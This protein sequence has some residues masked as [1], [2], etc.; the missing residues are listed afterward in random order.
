MSEPGHP[1]T[2]HGR[3][4]EW[5]LYAWAV[6]APLTLPVPGPDGVRISISDFLGAVTL[7][8]I[9]LTLLQRP[10]RAVAV[11]PVA[12]F[13]SWAL[14]CTI[15]NLPE[16]PSPIGALFRVSRA[17]FIA[18]PFL[19]AALFSAEL[20]PRVRSRVLDL[21][22]FGS[23]LGILIGIAAYYLGFS[24]VPAQTYD[25]GRGLVARATGMMGDAGAFG[26]LGSSAAALAL[27]LFFIER[28]PSFHRMILCFAL[29]AIM[30]LFFYTSLARAPLVDLAV[31]MLAIIGFAAFAIYRRGRVFARLGIAL[32]CAVAALGFV[33]EAYPVEWRTAVTRLDLEAIVAFADDPTSLLERLGS[34]RSNVWEE[35]LSLAED[36]IALGLGYKGLTSQYNLPGDN[37]FITTFADLGLPGVLILGSCLAA[38]SAACLWTTVQAGRTDLT[39][40]ILGPVWLGQLVHTIFV[41]IT[42]FYSSFPLILMIAGLAIFARPEAIRTGALSGSW[43]YRPGSWRM[44]A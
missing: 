35:S 32:G 7:V 26:H 22:M 6:L 31:V 9:V 42:T 18:S 30:P 36:H 12:I 8:L 34:G 25:Y 1:A 23:L 29:I 38:F 19:L 11:V 15:Y 24:V 37:L 28:R 27:C 10:R 4:A 41:D 16:Y 33:A 13:I 20:G 21:V 5:L 39:A 40:A 3:A 44:A 43:R 14:V 17:A 2:A